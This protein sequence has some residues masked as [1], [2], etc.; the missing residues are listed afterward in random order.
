[1]I[2]SQTVVPAVVG[3]MLLNDDIRD[4]WYPVALIGFAVTGW[5]ALQLARFEQTTA[6]TST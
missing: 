2:V 4:G 6:P 5:G 3:V 1:M